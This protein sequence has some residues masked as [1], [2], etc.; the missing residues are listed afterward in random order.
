MAHVKA[1][2]LSLVC[3]NGLMY[4]LTMPCNYQD[5]ENTHCDRTYGDMWET[6]VHCNHSKFSKTFIERDYKRFDAEE[7]DPTYD[8][9]FGCWDLSVGKTTYL[10]SYLEIDG[11]VYCDIRDEYEG[12]DP[13]I[14]NSEEDNQ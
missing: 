13:R 5:R 12:Y 8:N 6:G 4:P 10:C 7:H 11:R 14:S 2:I 9:Q 3:C 1:E